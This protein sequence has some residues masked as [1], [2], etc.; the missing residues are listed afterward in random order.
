MSIGHRPLMGRPND[1]CLVCGDRNPQGLRLCFA[2]EGDHAVTAI[3]RTNDAWEGFRGMIHGG[4]VSTVLDEAMSKAVAAVGI[5]A[6]TCE[7]RVRLRQRVKVAEELRVR[8]WVVERRKRRI[9]AEATLKDLEG[10][11]R[12]HAWATFLELPQ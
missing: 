12:A 6:L 10:L 9:T 2:P 5:C 11:E 1:R 8:G 4:I 3:W 7:L